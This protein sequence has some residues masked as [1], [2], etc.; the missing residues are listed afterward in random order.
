MDNS[1]LIEFSFGIMLSI[2]GYFLKM[3]M[4]RFDKLEGKVIQNKEDITR[5]TTKAEVM[6]VTIQGRLTRLDEKFDAMQQ[7][8]EMLVKDIKELGT[9][10]RNNSKY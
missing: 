9:S 2:V 1:Y 8:I 6:E 3:T 5:N 7:S 4:T 10:I